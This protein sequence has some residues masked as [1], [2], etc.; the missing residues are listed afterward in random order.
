MGGAGEVVVNWGGGLLGGE[1]VVGEGG[2]LL[3]GEVVVS[4]RGGIGVGGYLGERGIVVE[5]S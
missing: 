1:V 2:G 5:G 4:R 3:G